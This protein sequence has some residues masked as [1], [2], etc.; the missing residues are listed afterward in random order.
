MHRWST[1][2]LIYLPQNSNDGKMQIIPFILF[3]PLV[4]LTPY[5]VHIHSENH[6]PHEAHILFC[7]TFRVFSDANIISY[8]AFSALTSNIVCLIHVRRRF[9][10]Q[11]SNNNK[12]YEFHLPQVDYKLKLSKEQLVAEVKVNSELICD[13]QKCMR[14]NR[15]FVYFKLQNYDGLVVRSDTKIT[16]EVLDAGAGHVKV[17]GR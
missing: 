11:L 14:Y 16:A 8:A 7:S 5:S 17:V 6:S 2:R 1:S 13:K 12:I 15:I 9:I 4:L 3:F 10:T